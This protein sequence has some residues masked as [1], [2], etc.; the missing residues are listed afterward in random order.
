MDKIFIKGLRFDAI[1]GVYEWERLSTQTIVLDLELMVDN[2]VAASKD[3]IS[4]ALDYAKA[5]EMAQRIAVEGKYQLVETLAEAIAT[6]LA[7]EF[8]VP[9]MKIRVTK[10]DALANADGVGVEIVR[11]YR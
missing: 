6:R 7:G 3:A 4:D 8:Q 5:A 11:D 2:R 1:L 9:W 10:P